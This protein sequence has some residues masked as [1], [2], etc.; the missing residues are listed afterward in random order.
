[1]MDKFDQVEFK[2]IFVLN[3]ANDDEEASQETVEEILR[4]TDRD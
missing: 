3:K 4:S 1:M 2:N